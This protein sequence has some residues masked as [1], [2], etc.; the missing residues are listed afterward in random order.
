MRR[1]STAQLLGLAALLSACDGYPTEDEPL[2]N[3]FDMSPTQ[4]VA[5]I[6]SSAARTISATADAQASPA[7]R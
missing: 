6:G 5:R 7:R 1:R 3:P 4:R 2:H